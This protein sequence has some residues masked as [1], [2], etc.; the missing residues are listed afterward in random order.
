MFSNVTFAFD[1]NPAAGHSLRPRAAA[2]TR[3]PGAVSR[4]IAITSSKPAGDVNQKAQKAL[5]VITE[6]VRADILE[7]IKKRAQERGNRVL[8]GE[9]AVEEARWIVHEVITRSIKA[10]TLTDPY[11]SKIL[12]PATQDSVLYFHLQDAEMYVRR[13][14]PDATPAVPITALWH[15]ISRGFDDIARQMSPSTDERGRKIETGS[16][17]FYRQYHVVHPA[18]SAKLLRE[19]LE[20]ANIYPSIIKDAETLIRY[21]EVGGKGFKAGGLKPI[22]ARSGLYQMADAVMN[23]DAVSLFGRLFPHCTEYY[24]KERI[25][26]TSTDRYA[27]MSPEAQRI[28]DDEMKRLFTRQPEVYNFFLEIKSEALRKI[29]VQLTNDWQNWEK[30]EPEILRLA[31]ELWKQPRPIKPIIVAAG[32]GTRARQSGIEVVKPLAPINGKPALVYV[33]EAIAAL[34]DKIK[35]ER[36]LIIVSPETESEVK[37][38]LSRS[39]YDINRDFEFVV[40]KEAWGTGHAVLQAKKPLKNFSGDALVIWSTQPAITTTTL[41]NSIIIHQAAGNAAMTVPTAVFGLGKH[42]AERKTPYAPLVRDK[43]GHVQEIWE[44]HLEEKEVPSKG[45]DN[46]GAFIVRSRDLFAALEQAHKRLFDEVAGAYRAPGELGFPNEMVR[47]LAKEQGKL[48]LGLALADTREQHGIKEKPD[49]NVLG[50]YI[51]EI[52]TSEMLAASI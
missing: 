51:K 43:N 18:E 42:Q 26:Q 37:E 14:M 17:E 38:A 30:N 2:E 11:F 31:A 19:F 13:F 5:S 33:L 20:A 24:G 21:H 34:G 22:D 41:L 47:T 25:F 36:P 50:R 27:K 4:G 6:S 48:V 1:R 52:A 28:A 9:E 32:K 46:I 29:L 44:S 7:T 15:D 3:M 49:L 8:V 40:Q 45:E 35:L 12:D 23:A 16:I 39:G 10:G